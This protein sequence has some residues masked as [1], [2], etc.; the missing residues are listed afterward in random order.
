MSLGS[1]AHIWIRRLLSVPDNF[2][3]RL[4]VL[5]IEWCDDDLWRVIVLNDEMIPVLGINPLF[6]DMARR[7]GEAKAFLA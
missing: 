5:E 2:P 4:A 7:K 3:A 6:A 1:H